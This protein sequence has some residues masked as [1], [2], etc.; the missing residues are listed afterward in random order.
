MLY[1]REDTDW[2]ARRRN[3]ISPSFILVLAVNKQRAEK[4]YLK[5]IKVELK[6]VSVVLCCSTTH[7]IYAAKLTLLVSRADISAF[8]PRTKSAAS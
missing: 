3:F 8:A 4:G 6:C 7:I 2:I 5:I 1:I